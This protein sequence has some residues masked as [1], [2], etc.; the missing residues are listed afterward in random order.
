[1]GDILQ[2]SPICCVFVV[3]VVVVV[4]NPLSNLFSV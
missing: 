1:M 2:K 4:F 3:V